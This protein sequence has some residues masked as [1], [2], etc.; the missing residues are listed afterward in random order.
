MWS[1][2]RRNSVAS[3]WNLMVLTMLMEELNS[4]MEIF[5]YGITKV[6]N[7]NIRSLNPT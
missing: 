2:L 7:L 4:R 5:S 3:Y 1:V 6:K